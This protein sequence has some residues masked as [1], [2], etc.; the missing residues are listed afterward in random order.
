[1]ALRGTLFLALAVGIRLVAPAGTDA[2][3]YSWTSGT[4]GLWSTPANWQSSVAPPAGGGAG[5]TLSFA[6]VANGNVSASNDL[7]NPFLANELE[8][9]PRYGLIF[10]SPATFL[11][12]EVTNAGGNSLLL[13][14]VAPRIVNASSAN[15]RLT[16]NVQLG[17]NSLLTGA[18]SGNLLLSGNLT[19]SSG[20]IVNATGRGQFILA[21]TNNTF[22]GGVTLMAGNLSIDNGTALGT[23]LVTVEGGTLRFNSFSSPAGHVVANGFQLNQDLVIRGN[24]SCVFSGLLSGNGGLSNRSDA[25]ISVRLTNSNTYSGATQAL[26]SPTL[27]G[28]TISLEGVNGSAVNSSAFNVA[29]FS[30]LLLDNRNTPGSG[31]TGGGNNL[32]RIGDSTPVNLASRS[33]LSFFANET[34][35]S[36]ETIGSLNTG[37]SPFVTLNQGITATNRSA[38]LTANTFNPGA[39]SMTLFRGI[40]LG[41]AAPGT[42]G[43]D[44]V[45]FGNSGNILSD[46]RGG[47]G[48]PGTSTISVMPYAF[49]HFNNGT[50]S[51]TWFGGGNSLVTYDVNFGVRPLNSTTEYATTIIS[52]TASLNNVRLIAPLTGIDADTTINA[53]VLDRTNASTYGQVAGTG[54]LRISSGLVLAAGASGGPVNRNAISVAT[55]DF[56]SREG[57]IIAPEVI[58]IS[59]NL[60]G[61]AGLHK[62]AGFDL[63]LTGNNSGLTGP[64]TISGGR[65]FVASTSNLG[66]TGDVRLNGGFLSY[67]ASDTLG[68]SRGVQLGEAHGWLEASAGVTLTVSGT[69]SGTG[70]LVKVGAGTVVLSGTNTY[71]GSTVMSAGVLSVGAAGNLGATSG[72]VLAPGGTFRNTGTMTLGQDWTLTAGAGTRTLETLADLTL[73]GGIGHNGVPTNALTLAKTGP[74]TLNLNG[75]NTFNGVLSVNAGT[76]R[77]NQF[78]GQVNTVNGAQTATDFGVIVASGAGLG[79]VGLIQRDINFQAASILTPGS[80]PGTLTV[81]GLVNFSGNFFYDWEAGSGGQD[82]LTV[83]GPVN[84]NGGTA[85]IRLFDL[86]GF[87]PNPMT[88]YVLIS[89]EGISGTLPTF[90]VDYS[91]AP[92]WSDALVRQVGNNIVLSNLTAIPEPGSL[93]LASVGFGLFARWRRRRGCR[94]AR[95]SRRP[96]SK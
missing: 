24:N 36:S 7:G 92:E 74:A 16:A 45:L 86:G 12:T 13:T 68:P 65:I 64:I 82:R 89:S 15:S 58:T 22:S 87:I 21:G 54:I 55:L 52:G 40:N 94:A 67:T 75:V 81:R 23:G 48:G 59:S 66:G 73:T 32:N 31:L 95:T 78:L 25:G 90:V 93:L 20:V 19:G 37:G 1:M 33:I 2:Q 70:S 43:N 17:A 34:A 56:G 39:S 46:L 63:T 9:R 80:S 53:L 10:G 60:T 47:G 57:V 27:V 29:R 88:D 91:N 71:T 14:G 18:G 4:S 85:T 84:F 76:V 28:S 49:G 38:V 26:L 41:G 11:G 72:F 83:E 35:A 30:T 6:S 5:L 61:T 8:F 3:S 79:G 77:V 51:T 50:S 96:A 42:P 69:V 62:A 44:N